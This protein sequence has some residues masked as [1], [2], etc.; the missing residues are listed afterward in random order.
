MEHVL[1][2]VPV[3]R[4]EAELPALFQSRREALK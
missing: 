3:L 1:C 2:E 4:R